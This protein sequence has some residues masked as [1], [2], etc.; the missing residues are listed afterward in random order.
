[1]APV[2]Q[3]LGIDLVHFGVLSTVNLAI[4]QVTPPVGVNLFVA[5][6]IKI[7]DGVTVTM[8]EISKAVAPMIIA[9]V[10]ALMLIT[11]VPACSLILLGR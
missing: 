6:G 8:A 4:G 9:C 11:Y 1:M 10:I 7:K 5:I 2:A 3:K